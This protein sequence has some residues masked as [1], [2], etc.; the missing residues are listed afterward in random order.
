MLYCTAWRAHSLEL[1]LHSHPRISLCLLSLIHLTT[2]P[3]STRLNRPFLLAH[4]FSPVDLPTSFGVLP[5]HVSPQFL[6]R[7]QPLLHAGFY[8]LPRVLNLPSLI[9]CPLSGIERPIDPF[10]TH[11]LSLAPFVMM[12]YLLYFFFATFLL[13][14]STFGTLFSRSSHAC[15]LKSA[16][17]LLRFSP[18]AE[19]TSFSVY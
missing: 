1:N 14:D 2:A 17:A 11:S 18:H 15:L 13:S 6:P 3:T 10:C 19:V 8:L 5:F 12:V 9:P 4:R 7:P 16:P